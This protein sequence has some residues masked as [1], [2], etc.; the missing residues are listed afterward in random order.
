M[1]QRILKINYTQVAA[2]L[3]ERLASSQDPDGPPHS[4]TFGC[5]HGILSSLFNDY[6][7]ELN[8]PFGKEH[9]T[10]VPYGTIGTE[11]QGLTDILFED[12]GADSF[13]DVVISSSP[14]VVAWYKENPIVFPLVLIK[15]S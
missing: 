11:A 9:L 7:G 6:E 5:V 14:G 2:Y 15:V 1:A 4:L 8:Y 13:D 10:E 3:G 12:L